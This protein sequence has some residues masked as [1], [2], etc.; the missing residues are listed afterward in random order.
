MM[1][2]NSI[3]ALQSIDEFASSDL[4]VVAQQ[5][6]YLHNKFT[7]CSISGDGFLDVLVNK[8]LDIRK[9]GS[10]AYEESAMFSPFVHSH[11]DLYNKVALNFLYGKD[12]DALSMG[13][14]FIDGTL[15]PLYVPTSAVVDII[16]I[17]F[18]I[19]EPK[20]G[21]LKFVASPSI[22]LNS[23]IDYRS[24]SFDGWLYPDGSTFQLSD[25]ILSSQ[26]DALYGN[27]NQ[28]F[29]LPDLRIFLKMN[30]DQSK[31]GDS[32]KVRLSNNVEVK[33]Q[34]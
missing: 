24:D 8:V 6:K 13:N 21:M 2:E 3:S 25:F 7:T 17:P 16:K 33:V 18:Q 31:V 1:S 29:T 28:T 15:I 34:S 10:A 22:S 23:E 27:D 19:I 30:G 4:F 26:L 14:M 5:D 9:F 12:D 32:I 11:D 20:V